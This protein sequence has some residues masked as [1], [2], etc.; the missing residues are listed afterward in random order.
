MK[1]PY[2]ESNVNIFIQILTYFSYLFL[3]FS[4]FFS[5]IAIFWRLY[6]LVRF[7]EEIDLS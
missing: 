1:T 4:I 7:D 6:R 2:E 3:G 5:I